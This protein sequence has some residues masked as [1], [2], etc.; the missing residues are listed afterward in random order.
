MSI[1]A[2][3][4]ITLSC[5]VDVEAITFYYLLQS[6]TLATPS[7][8]TTNPP[9]G[10]T[11]TEP[12]YVDGSTNSLYYCQLVEFSDGTWNYSNVSLSSSYEAAKLAYNK[13]QNAQ[14]TANSANNKADELYSD[15]SEI[16]TDVANL[17]VAKDSITA[18][19]ESLKSTTTETGNSLTSLTESYNAFV[20]QT[21][22]SISATLT[23]AME[24]TDGLTAHAREISTY[25]EASEEGLRISQSDS[26]DTDTNRT[27]TLMAPDS[28]QVQFDGIAS[29]TV[30]REG[31][32][33]GSLWL[34]TAL[35]LNPLIFTGYGSGESGGVVIK[36]R[37]FD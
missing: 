20:A 13:A 23:S 7:A 18:S 27:S 35:T 8:P 17:E 30:F 33:T 5:I 2:R 22:D 25:F 32:E 15:V 1:I 28:F 16:T 31:I 34:S 3:D 24:Y 36:W 37:G 4:E 21:S 14:D 26:G 6:S 12:T 11:D 10:W 29:T 9:S 19:V